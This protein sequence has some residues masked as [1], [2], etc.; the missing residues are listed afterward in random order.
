[1]LQQA[2]DRAREEIVAAGLAGASIQRNGNEFAIEVRESAAAQ[3]SYDRLR[4]TL[5]VTL[6]AERYGYFEQ[7]GCAEGVEQL[8]KKL[9]LATITY[10]VT[11]VPERRRPNVQYEL[12]QR[13]AHAGLGGSE[14]GFPD[15]PTMLLNLG[16]FATLVPPDL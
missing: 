6:G 2:A 16:P 10:I 11:R 14:S 9:G 3:A 13:L 8:F 4:A 5:Q 7:I 12:T 15:R 1:M